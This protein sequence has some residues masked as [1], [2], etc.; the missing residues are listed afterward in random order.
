[1]NS[2]DRRISAEGLPAA[3]GSSPW[4]SFTGTLA[5][6]PAAG[7]RNSRQ[8]FTLIELLVVIAI[9]AIL[10]ALLLPALSRAKEMTRSVQ[11]KSNLHQVG[12]ALGMY[13]QDNGGK[14]PEFR[15]LGGEWDG[16]LNEQGIPYYLASWVPLLLP[17]ESGASAVFLC[18]STMG[19]PTPARFAPDFDPRVPFWSGPTYDYNTR[20]TDR[21]NS[22]LRLGLAW[23]ICFRWPWGDPGLGTNDVND[24]LETQVK[25]P[26]DMIAF[27][28]PS[29]GFSPSDIGPDLSSNSSTGGL[30]FN[31]GSIASSP[32]S[33]DNS[34]PLQFPTDPPGHNGNANEL[35]ATATWR[36]K[37]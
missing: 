13:I 6:S 35:F 23:A 36:P 22:R 19:Q 10:A 20:G 8:G 31:L 26:S 2:I 34:W 1:M 24:V 3:Q 16:S 28:E 25:V 4:T 7:D 27:S 9:I 33:S 15:Q 21:Q 29:C 5:A 11:C 18:P 37:N 14:Y 12:L 17:Y 32:A 30:G